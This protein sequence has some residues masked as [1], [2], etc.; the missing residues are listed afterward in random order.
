M[1]Q[2]KGPMKN[3]YNKRG[4]LR[5]QVLKRD[6]YRCQFCRKKKKDQELQVHHKIPR[7]DGGQNT[8]DNLETVCPPCHKT[9][10][11]KRNMIT[12]PLTRGTFHRLR[13]L[14]DQRESIEEIIGRLI[15]S[16]KGRNHLGLF[17]SGS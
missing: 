14:T 8:I 3:I 7:R 15:E 16:S 9:I 2:R 11:P 1:K 6:K 17:L 10:E 12:V 4:K 5:Q 13:A